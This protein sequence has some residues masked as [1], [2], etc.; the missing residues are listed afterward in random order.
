[1][2]SLV[3]EQDNA[4]GGEPFNTDACLGAHTYFHE[5]GKAQRK[6][7]LGNM[8]ESTFVHGECPSPGFSAFGGKQRPSA[9]ASPWEVQVGGAA[10]GT[11]QVR[12]RGPE[13]PRE[14]LR[15]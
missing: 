15:Q 14:H 1:M 9:A 8:G 10:R 13:G 11:D 6:N 12:G 2:T 3:V 7:A 4:L 5:K